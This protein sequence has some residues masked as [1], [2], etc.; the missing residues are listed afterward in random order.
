MLPCVY[1][2]TSIC[3]R[4]DV[5][6]GYQVSSSIVLPFSL[7]AGFCLNLDSHFTAKWE[8]NKLQGTSCLCPWQSYVYRCVHDSLAVLWMLDSVVSAF[9][10][11]AISQFL[12][13]GIILI[14]NKH[15]WTLLTTITKHLQSHFRL[16][17]SLN[18][19]QT[20]VKLMSPL[21]TFTIPVNVKGSVSPYLFSSEEVLSTLRARFI[22]EDH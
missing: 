10:C 1:M 21:A 9:N 12:C 17:S 13:F 3:T 4:T 7:E 15:Y 18:S 8:V 20:T 11:W 2:Y 19:T 22:I 6:K 14:R 16:T 5:R